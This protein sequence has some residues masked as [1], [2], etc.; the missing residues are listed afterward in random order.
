MNFNLYNIYVYIIMMVIK[1]WLYSTSVDILHLAY[2]CVG[3]LWTGY[4]LGGLDIFF[5]H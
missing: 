3:N 1:R 2:V 4:T 5:L